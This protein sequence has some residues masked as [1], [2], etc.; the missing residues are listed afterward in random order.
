MHVENAPSARI[1]SIG[2]A[3]DEMGKMNRLKSGG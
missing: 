2:I 3:D 1:L